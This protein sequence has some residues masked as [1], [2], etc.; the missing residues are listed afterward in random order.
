MPEPSFDP[1]KSQKKY[2]KTHRAQ[3]SKLNRE[4]RHRIGINTPMSENKACSSWLGVVVAENI[5]LLTHVFGEVQKMPYG[6]K[7]VDY[8]CGKKKKIDSKCSCLHRDRWGATYWKIG[9][10]KNRGADFFWILLFNNRDDLKP[11]H[12]LLI[13]GPV[14]NGLQCLKITNTPE[15]FEKWIKFEQP[16]DKIV[17]C[18]DQLKAEATP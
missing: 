15:S 1:Y 12:A 11:I 13:P 2:N 3:R 10:K 7:G 8:I 16:L 6:N 4:W 17:V 9:I 18:C 14:V 5:R